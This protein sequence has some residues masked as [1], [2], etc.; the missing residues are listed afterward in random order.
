MITKNEAFGQALQEIRDKRHKATECADRLR[1]QLLTT[2]SAFKTVEQELIALSHKKMKA[3]I[4]KD[5]SYGTLDC[6]YTALQLKREAILNDLG[7]TDKD[8]S[9]AYACSAC[10]DRGY[11][12]NGYCE[13]V[14]QK[15]HTIMLNDLCDEIPA[16]SYSFDTFELDHYSDEEQKRHMSLILTRCKNYA[17]QFNKQ[18]DSLY[19]MGNTGLGKT[20]L[21]LSIA[22]A[23]V[24]KGYSVIYCS[25]QNMISALE[26]EH[27]GQLDHPVSKYYLDCDLL[28]I[29][30]LGTEFLSAVAQSELYNVI[31][32]RSLMQM[33]TIINSNLSPKELEI[34]Y[35]ERL[36]S[37]IIGCYATLHFVGKDFRIQKR[38]FSKKV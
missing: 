25:S 21:T 5:P 32:H 10:E 29:D 19:L 14:K 7:Y 31:N 6:E 20:H 37:R 16:G 11:T 34:R 1:E 4:T 22:K 36:L 12:D 38:L 17:E 8:L 27:F 15:A 30:D 33:P 9:P 24:A 2:S 23:V 18:A 35:G 13:C 28:I 26:K 3:K